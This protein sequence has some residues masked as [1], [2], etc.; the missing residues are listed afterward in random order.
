MRICWRTSATAMRSVN[1]KLLAALAGGLTPICCV[2]ETLA[3][4]QADDTDVVV[5]DR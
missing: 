3:E 1:R 2:G 4:R 5:P